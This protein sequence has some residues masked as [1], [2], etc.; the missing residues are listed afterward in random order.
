MSPSLCRAKTFCHYVV[1][2]LH[3]QDFLSFQSIE[4]QGLPLFLVHPY[5]SLSSYSKYMSECFLFQSVRISMG[6]V[7]ASARAESPRAESP[8]PHYVQIYLRPALSSKFLLDM[9]SLSN[10]C[11]TYGIAPSSESMSGISF[12]SMSNTCVYC[13][14][15]ECTRVCECPKE[16]SIGAL[17]R[18]IQLEKESSRAYHIGWCQVNGYTFQLL[19]LFHHE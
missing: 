5:F 4:Q 11:Q 3:S 8:R 18:S 15:I 19:H 9:L 14:C 12:K 7:S 17:P 10:T 13:V 1:T 2:N 16:R 6:T